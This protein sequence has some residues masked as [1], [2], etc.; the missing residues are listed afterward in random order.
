M[1]C[2]VYEKL[3]EDFC[4]EKGK[5]LAELPRFTLGTFLFNLLINDLGIKNRKQMNEHMKLADSTKL[6]DTTDAEENWNITQE[7][8]YDLKNCRKRNRAEFQGK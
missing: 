6:E 8:L 7:D 1:N 3:T 5:L 4:Q 2:K